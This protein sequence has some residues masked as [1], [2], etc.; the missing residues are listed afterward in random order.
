[1]NSTE[2]SNS[3]KTFVPITSR[4]SASGGPVV[5]KGQPG[6]YSTSG[7]AVVLLWEVVT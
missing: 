3:I 7:G 5:G 4:N 1:V 2:E 6:H